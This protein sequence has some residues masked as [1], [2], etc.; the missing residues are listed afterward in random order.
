[1]I[2]FRGSCIAFLCMIDSFWNCISFCYW[3]LS[4][5]C[6]WKV[7]FLLIVCR[8]DL[9]TSLELTWRCSRFSLGVLCF[10]RNCLL[11]IFLYFVRMQC[12][13]WFCHEIAK[14]GDCKCL[15]FDWR[16][17]LTKSQ[18]GSICKGSLE[19]KKPHC[20]I[21]SFKEGSTLDSTLVWRDVVAHTHIPCM[22]VFLI[23][24]FS[25]LGVCFFVC[26]L[27]CH[28]RH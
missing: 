6:S 4:H 10:C 24:V 17:S 22:F 13:W 2:A 15:T 28:D 1:M 11:T 16:I 14:G 18:W 21:K 12:E 8:L 19:C 20:V 25:C 27:P 9:S 23:V 26:W 3:H 5:T 7:Y